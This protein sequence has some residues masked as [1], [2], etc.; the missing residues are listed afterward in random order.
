M[1]TFLVLAC[2]VA[3]GIVAT[4][5]YYPE[6]DYHPPCNPNCDQSDPNVKA[7]CGSEY[8]PCL[9]KARGD[10]F[11]TCMTKIEADARIRWNEEKQ[12]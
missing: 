7:S 12:S 4:A 11:D 9:C 10:N 1:N 3:C 5:R 2:L 6:V 8:R